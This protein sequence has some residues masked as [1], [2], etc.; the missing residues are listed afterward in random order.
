MTQPTS[1]RPTWE[2]SGF[3][4]EIDADPVVQVAVLQAL[5]ERAKAARA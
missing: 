5:G 3:G 4:D 2:L 1:D